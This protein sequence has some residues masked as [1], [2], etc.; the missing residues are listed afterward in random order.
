MNDRLRG[1]IRGARLGPM[2]AA[3][4]PSSRGCLL[5]VLVWTAVNFGTIAPVMT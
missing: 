5:R 3:L 2:T 4:C 1:A